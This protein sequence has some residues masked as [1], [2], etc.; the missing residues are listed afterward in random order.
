[1]FIQIKAIMPFPAAAEAH[2][3]I[4]TDIVSRGLEL[5]NVK[6]VIS[7]SLPKEV[8]KNQNRR[9]TIEKFTNQVL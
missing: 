3:L 6:H 1:M 9:L 7:F 8:F 5:Q 4:L 2:V